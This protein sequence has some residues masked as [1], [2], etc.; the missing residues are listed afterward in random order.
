[1]MAEGMTKAD[2]VAFDTSYKTFLTNI[3]AI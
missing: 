2:M 1:M 3:G